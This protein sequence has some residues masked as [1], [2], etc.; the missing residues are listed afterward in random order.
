VVILNRL[1]MLQ[2]AV[3]HAYNTHLEDWISESEKNNDLFLIGICNRNAMHHDTFKL[4]RQRIS[5]DDPDVAL[6][7]L[8]L[9][10]Y[11][12]NKSVA[13]AGISQAAKKTEGMPSGHLALMAQRLSMQEGMIQV[14]HIDQE[15]AYSC[16]ASIQQPK[17]FNLGLY[18]AAASYTVPLLLHAW[19]IAAD[20]HLVGDTDGRRYFRSKLLCLTPLILGGMQLWVKGTLS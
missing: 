13:Q 4:F 12:A 19:D 10:H 15:V 9:E 1:H 5:I 11:L 8:I 17:K 3:P 14:D 7:Q 6:R 18:M 20:K 2:Y 16:V